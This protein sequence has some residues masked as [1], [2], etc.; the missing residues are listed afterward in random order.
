MNLFCILVARHYGDFLSTRMVDV[1]FPEDV[2]LGHLCEKG[3]DVT[4]GC[5]AEIRGVDFLFCYVEWWA[6]ALGADE[7]G[8][9]RLR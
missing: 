9:S 2:H 3:V 5:L 7:G 1:A 6:V 4:G 8:D